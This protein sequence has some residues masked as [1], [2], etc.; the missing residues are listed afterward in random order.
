M[1]PFL[2]ASIFVAAPRVAEFASLPEGKVITLAVYESSYPTKPK[3]GQRSFLS[4]KLRQQRADAREHMGLLF[5]LWHAATAE[6]DQRGDTQLSGNLSKPATGEGA[7]GIV[8]AEC[9]RI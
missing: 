5:G 7:S 6:R 3:A 2:F 4:R 8:A 9:G 1:R